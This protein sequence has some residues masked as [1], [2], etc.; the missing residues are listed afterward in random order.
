MQR[1]G[2]HQGTSDLLPLGHVDGVHGADADAVEGVLEEEGAG[3][4]LGVLVVPVHHRDGDRGAGVEALGRA[5]L[6]DPREFRENRHRLGD[7]WVMMKF[8]GF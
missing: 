4:E 5:H 6:L 3:Q 7:V 2:Q 1:E 8:S